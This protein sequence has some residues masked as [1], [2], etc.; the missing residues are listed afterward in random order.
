MVKGGVCSGLQICIVMHILI[1]L[2]CIVLI[3]KMLI[4]IKVLFKY[5]L[6]GCHVVTNLADFIAN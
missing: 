6:I 5:I 2:L 1:L 4:Y 3:F